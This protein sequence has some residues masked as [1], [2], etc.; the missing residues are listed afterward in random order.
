MVWVW[1]GLVVAVLVPVAVLAY[2]R[3]RALGEITR[4]VRAL[5]EGKTTRPIL[6]RVGGAVGRLARL[7]D[8]VAPQLEARIARLEQ[9]RQQLRAVLSGMAEGVIAIDARRRLVFA[10]ASADRLFGLN[11]ASVGRLVPELIRSPQIQE[12]VEATLAGTGPYQGEITVAR[13][14]AVLHVQARVLAV[15]GTPL[16][17]S[18]PPGAVLVF[19]DVTELRRLERMRQD[20]VANA[21][22]ELK[23]PLASIKAYT[24]TLLDWAIRDDSVNEKFLHRIEEQADRLNQLI[25]DLLSLAR[26][27]SGQAVYEHGPLAFAPVI[28]ACDRR[29][30]PPRLRTP[31]QEPHPRARP[32]LPA[33]RTRPSS[34]WPTRRRSGRSSTT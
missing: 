18:P 1:V 19:H 10:N 22:H 34:T 15:H 24:E 12:A 28:G 30:H 16:P 20:F 17:G 32:R 3:A 6:A 9:D 26:L 31:S 29:S 21:S 23:T 14:E 33:R 4:A 11:A 25:M 5:G 2:R 7:F 27:E 13:R 8:A